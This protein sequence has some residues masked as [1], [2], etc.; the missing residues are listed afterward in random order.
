MS[1]WVISHGAQYER[2]GRAQIKASSP[3]TVLSASYTPTRRTS[4]V[5]L[6]VRRVVTHQDSITERTLPSSPVDAAAG[7][8]RTARAP[9]TSPNAAPA[10]T[11]NDREIRGAIN[12]KAMPY[13]APVTMWIS[14]LT[15]AGP[16]A[17]QNLLPA[18]VSATEVIIDFGVPVSVGQRARVSVLLLH[19]HHIIDTSDCR[20]DR[21]NLERHPHDP[22]IREFHRAVGADVVADRNGRTISSHSHH[23]PTDARSRLTT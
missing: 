21:A 18:I 5:A 17:N 22:R 11:R 20:G 19:R 23:S 10:G 2:P 15:A 16:V 13:I 4:R 1:P 9:S 14:S 12:A 6:R 7:T 3:R 8:L